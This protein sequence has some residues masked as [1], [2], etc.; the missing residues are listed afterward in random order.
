LEDHNLAGGGVRI[1]IGTAGE[2][3]TRQA[4]KENQDE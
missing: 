2:S 4:E 1:I 3:L